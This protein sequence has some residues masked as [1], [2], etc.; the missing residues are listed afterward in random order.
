MKKI[1]EVWTQYK[2]EVGVKLFSGTKWACNAY[3]RQAIAKGAK[4]NHFAI[5]V[6]S[7]REEK[8]SKCES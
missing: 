8:R 4:P 5:L 7:A 2:G 6:H 1:Y 3:I